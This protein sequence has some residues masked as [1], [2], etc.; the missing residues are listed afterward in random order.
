MKRD[1]DDPDANGTETAHPCDANP[2]GSPAREL[3]LSSP[4]VEGLADAC[5]EE[6]EGGRS[7]AKQPRLKAPA[8][9]PVGALVAPPGAEVGAGAS[10]PAAAPAAAQAMLANGVQAVAHSPAEDEDEELVEKEIAAIQD[11][12][13]TLE[14]RL[15][16]L[17]A[18]H[19]LLQK[20]YTSAALA[21]PK[22]RAPHDPSWEVHSNPANG[23]QYYWNRRTQASTYDRPVDYNPRPKPEVPPSVNVKGPPGA[24]L[25]VVRKMRR[26]DFDDFDDA[27][28][29]EAFSSYGTVL[30]CEIATDPQ[31]GWSRGFGWVSFSQ[32]E[33]ALAAITALHG[34]TVAGRE[35]KVEQTKEDA[36]AMVT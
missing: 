9:E 35:L 11:D 4:A 17:Q 24:N 27:D 32:R 7:A 20:A 14:G 3:L 34:A 19:S 15:A 6:H 5:Q 31:T 28:L 30:R 2:A 26:G 16:T 1:R 23:A 29:R 36:G 22:L 10:A 25:F 12:I 8:A 33:E 18:E 21:A 13:R